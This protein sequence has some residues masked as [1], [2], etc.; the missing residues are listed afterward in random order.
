MADWANRA[1]ESWPSHSYGSRLE[2]TI[3]ED[4]HQERFW[5]VA[6]EVRVGCLVVT[7]VLLVEHVAEA[8]F[9]AFV[10]LVAVL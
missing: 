5:D 10:R 4:A 1:S 7:Q 9:G 2:V 8:G 3:V 6:V